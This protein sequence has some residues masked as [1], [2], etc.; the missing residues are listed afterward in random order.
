[1]GRIEERAGHV[2]EK[3]GRVDENAGCADVKAKQSLS[4]AFSKRTRNVLPVVH[5]FSSPFLHGLTP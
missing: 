1:M 5:T 3:E 2:E 4:F